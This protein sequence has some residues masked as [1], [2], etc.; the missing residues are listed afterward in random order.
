VR[1]TYNYLTRTVTVDIICD[2]TGDG[3]VSDTDV[4]GNTIALTWPTPELCIGGTSAGVYFLVAF[5]CA[6]A[7]VRP[8]AAVV[9]LMGR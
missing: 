6:S 7:L 1:L 3:S 8:A 5:A 9:E 2:T 4:G